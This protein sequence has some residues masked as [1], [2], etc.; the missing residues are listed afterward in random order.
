LKGPRSASGVG[1]FPGRFGA[2]QGKTMRAKSS[3]NG[4]F[5]T[6]PG[7]KQ[8]GLRVFFGGNV[9]AFLLHF[10]INLLIFLRL[11]SEKPITF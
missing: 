10:R 9:T 7:A 8:G 2:N 4:H 11:T 5:C 6:I 1:D 3:Q